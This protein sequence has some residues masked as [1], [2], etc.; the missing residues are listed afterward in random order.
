MHRSTRCPPRRC[1]CSRILRSACVNIYLLFQFTRLHFT[2]FVGMSVLWCGS[3]G[4]QESPARVCRVDAWSNPL[5]A[6]RD[7]CLAKLVREK[8][9]AMSQ[10][11][12][13]LRA[14][15]CVVT[16]SMLCGAVPAAIAC[17]M[18]TFRSRFEQEL[19]VHNCSAVTFQYVMFKQA[20]LVNS[21]ASNWKCR[22]LRGKGFLV[23]RANVQ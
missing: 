18:C 2:R 16:V 8:R 10:L 19:L 23:S 13:H 4:V 9:T 17:D 1:S 20:V 3:L 22:T 7:N 14:T 5:A 11:S 21:A 12:F 6:V 15:A